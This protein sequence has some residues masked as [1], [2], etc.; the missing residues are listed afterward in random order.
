M[1][2]KIIILGAVGNCIDILD[3]L[4]EINRDRRKTEF[5]C[6]G[7]LDDDETKWDQKING[8]KVLGS[9]STAAR[10]SDC[11]FVNGIGS[12]N[13]FWNKK[14]I[15]AKTQIPLERFETLIHPTASVSQWSKIGRGTVI[16]QGA[17]ITSNVLIG[18]HVVI[19][20]GSVISHDDVV[21]DFTCI[22][23]GACIAGRVR[24]GES[25]YIGTN[26]TIKEG[27]TVG[28]F[29]LIGM[30]SVVLKDVSDNSVLVGNPARFLRKTRV[31]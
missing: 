27:T 28:N 22:S 18:N 2:K 23:G 3:T 4:S 14:A 19:L 7:F 30:G 26:A 17:N 13:N 5:K 29:C 11:F 20:P 15:I 9:I 12:P 1:S 31:V 6:V 8:I 16:F 10:Y 21:G 24:I 25:S